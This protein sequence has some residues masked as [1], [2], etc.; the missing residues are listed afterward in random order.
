MNIHDIDDSMSQLAAD[1]KAAMAQAGAY[2]GLMLAPRTDLVASAGKMLC[3]KKWLDENNAIC[4]CIPGTCP[5]PICDLCNDTGGI[6]SA[7]R[8]PECQ[9]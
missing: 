2:T 6:A 5:D 9:P 8:C 4:D 1:A 7:S 3:G